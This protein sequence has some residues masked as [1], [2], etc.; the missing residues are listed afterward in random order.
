MNENNLYKTNEEN[1]TNFYQ[2]LYKL[3]LK[4]EDVKHI[5]NILNIIL[6]LQLKNEFIEY[7]D[8]IVT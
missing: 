3:D 5:I 1:I 2:F 7:H 4:I 6:D 8:E